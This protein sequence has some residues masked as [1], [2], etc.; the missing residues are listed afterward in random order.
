MIA[1][2]L[3]GFLVLIIYASWK[4]PTKYEPRYLETLQQR[5]KRLES[6]SE[7]ERIARHPSYCNCIICQ[8]DPSQ[9]ATFEDPFPN[10]DD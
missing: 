5:K 1:W 4:H 9:L 3:I 7:D 10:N 8:G 2:V 6:W